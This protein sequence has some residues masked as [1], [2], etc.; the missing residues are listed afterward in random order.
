MT[1]TA[2]TLGASR[3]LWELV[4]RRAELTPD[5]P[6]LLQGDRTLT[7]GALRE[8]CERVAAGLCAMGVRAGSVVAWQLPT[9]IE[10]AVL[11][12]AL[13]RLGAVQSPVIPFYRDREVGFALR[14][15][16]AEF[17]AVPSGVA[18]LRPHRHG[19]AARR[20]GSLRG[21]RPTTRW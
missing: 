2:H 5:R 1:D 18:R 6:V 10:T 3:T 4:E 12:F 13:A 20:A 19:A 7:F 9:R 11:S 14:A 21:V 17:F 8:R 16:K 15:S